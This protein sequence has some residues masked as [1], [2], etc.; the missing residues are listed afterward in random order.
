M[1]LQIKRKVG[2]TIIVGGLKAGDVVQLTISDVANGEVNV[3]VAA[4]DHAP[5]VRGELLNDESGVP[6]KRQK[7]GQRPSRLTG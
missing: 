4:P 1:A 2:Q 7:R 3:Q 6:M 5:I